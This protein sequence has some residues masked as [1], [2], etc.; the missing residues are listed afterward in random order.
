MDI[1]K[2]L[3]EMLIITV[4]LIEMK[5]RPGSLEEKMRFETALIEKWPEACRRAGVAVHEMPIDIVHMI[6]GV[7]GRCYLFSYSP[8]QG[9]CAAVVSR[10]LTSSS[11]ALVQR[12]IVSSIGVS[13]RCPAADIARHARP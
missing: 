5:G 12:P 11:P 4:E 13:G 10:T 2:A 7:G 8:S 9:A 1:C 3:A 6:A